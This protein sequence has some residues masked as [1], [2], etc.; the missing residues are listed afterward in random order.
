MKKF[1]IRMGSS[2]GYGSSM[3]REVI[4][5]F[6]KVHAGTGALSVFRD[7]SEVLLVV[8]GEWLEVNIT[9]LPKEESKPVEKKPVE[10][11]PVTKADVEELLTRPIK[12]GYGNDI[13]IRNEAEI[14]ND[15]ILNAI[16]KRRG[17]LD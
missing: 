5:D 8:A 4:G 1:T 15:E 13:D 6:H 10:K 9:E 2:G 3:E 17:S 11:K 12:L 7:R 16:R 14:E